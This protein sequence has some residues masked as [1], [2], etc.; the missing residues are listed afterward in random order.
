[1]EYTGQNQGRDGNIAWL[2]CALTVHYA[3]VNKI[4]MFSHILI[5]WPHGRG[6]AAYRLSSMACFKVSG[7]LCVV[8]I[9]IF[10]L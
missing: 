9:F 10:C 2:I 6:T 7:E 1:M 3:Y 5:R 4:Y 8:F